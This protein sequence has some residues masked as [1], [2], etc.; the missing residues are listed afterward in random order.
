MDEKADKKINNYFMGFG[1]FF[2]IVTL[3]MCS[4]IEMKTANIEQKMN[5]IDTKLNTTLEA[6]IKT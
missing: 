4:F 2:S 1:L 6:S 5:D 3:F